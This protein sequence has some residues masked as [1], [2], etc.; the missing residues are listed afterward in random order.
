M[1]FN[2]FVFLA[3]VEKNYNENEFLNFLSFYAKFC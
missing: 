2:F 1:K 3:A